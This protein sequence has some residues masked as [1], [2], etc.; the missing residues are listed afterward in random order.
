MSLSGL[1][2]SVFTKVEW[3]TFAPQAIVCL[4]AAVDHWNIMGSFKNHWSLDIV[5]NMDNYISVRKATLWQSPKF[6]Y[7]IKL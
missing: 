7:S 6:N 4:P 3:A 2:K 5:S 1:Q